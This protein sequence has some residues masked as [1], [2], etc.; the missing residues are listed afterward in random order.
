VISPSLCGAL[1]AALW[2]IALE[3]PPEGPLKGHTS[4]L[5]NGQLMRLLSTH[6][7]RMNG[8]FHA[9]G[10]RSAKVRGT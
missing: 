1:F 8:D 7:R 6:F 4:D 10:S 5:S 2:D 3:A 9:I